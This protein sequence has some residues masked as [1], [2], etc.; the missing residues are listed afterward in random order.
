MGHQAIQ[1]SKL[2]NYAVQSSSGENLG[3]IEDVIINPNSGRV[4]FAVLSLG[5][6]G[7]SPSSPSSPSAST[8]DTS[9][10]S[11]SGKQVAV[12]WS[13][14]RPASSQGSSA[15]STAAS[16]RSAGHAF[17]FNGEATKLQ[18]APTFDPNSDITQPSWRQSVF[19][20]FGVSAGSAT[21]GSDYP[22]SSSSSGSYR[23]SS[24]GSN[25]GSPSQ[26]S[27]SSPD[28]SSPRSTP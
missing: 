18:S 9:S 20:Y 21:G 8:S 4:D 14:L 22:G 3:T 25:S 19:S 24:S 16:P 12:P 27:S 17:T 1:A 10:S 5:S 15:S 28:S 23:G 6:S 13:L 11:G 7:S 2:K 26:D